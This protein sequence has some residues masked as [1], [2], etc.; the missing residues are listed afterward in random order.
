MKTW[1]T[2]LWLCLAIYIHFM[3]LLSDLLVFKRMYDYSSPHFG[4]A[5]LILLP[6][7]YCCA[8]TVNAVSAACLLNTQALTVF[9]PIFG[10]MPS[11]EL[12]RF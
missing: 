4:W 9:S 8:Y 2:V 11:Q 6:V 1:L 12:L 7:S 10:Y 3:A 5:E